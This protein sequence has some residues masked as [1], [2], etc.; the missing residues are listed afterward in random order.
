MELLALIAL[1]AAPVAPATPAPSI[2][3]IAQVDAR[4][5]EIE[6]EST[7]SVQLDGN[8]VASKDSQT[9]RNR[10]AGSRSQRDLSIRYR[11][12]VTLADPLAQA[13]SDEAPS[14]SAAS[15]ARDAEN[16][17]DITTDPPTG[18]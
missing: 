3:I 10:P 14:A 8:P 12:Q 7:V 13:W 6:G 18:S 11:A 17:T 4:S 2:E 15:T 16:D 5:V 1:Q 9:D